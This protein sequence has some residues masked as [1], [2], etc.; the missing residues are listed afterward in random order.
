VKKVFLLVMMFA[1]ILGFNTPVI[2]YHLLQLDITNDGVSY[3]P[4]NE[5]IVTQD[6][7]FDLVALLNTRNG[8]FGKLG[9]E[10]SQ[11]GSIPFF[12]VASWDNATGDKFEFDGS[13]VLLNSDTPSVFS[14]PKLNHGE[15]GSYGAVFSFYFDPGNTTTPYDTQLNPGEFAGP[16]DG[17]FLYR[18]FAVDVG[19]L[20]PFVP[21]HFDLFVWAGG[22]KIAA[23]FSHDASA[24]PEPATML[25]L[26]TGLLGLA[27]ARR[28]KFHR[29]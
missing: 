9:V 13:D 3:D 5:T 20:N 23:P 12:I 28:K 7:T 26:G 25:L 29:S 2:A 1:I 11:I 19:E 6:P 21:I 10:L 18:T 17:S 14:N 16:G 8:Q 24:V 27:A 4:T 15:L 22:D